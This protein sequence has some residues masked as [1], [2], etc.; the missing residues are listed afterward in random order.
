M[1]VVGLLV[2]I[3]DLFDQVL[4]KPSSHGHELLVINGFEQIIMDHQSWL[5]T[6]Y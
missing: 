1:A 2:A 5:W 3:N 4:S 6:D